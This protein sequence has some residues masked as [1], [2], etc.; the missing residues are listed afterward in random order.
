MDEEESKLYYDHE[1]LPLLLALD[2]LYWGK[3]KLTRWFFKPWHDA[4]ITVALMLCGPELINQATESY[5]LDDST[6]QSIER[7]LATQRK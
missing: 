6:I 2:T 4:L 1:I 3:P 7:F 5:K